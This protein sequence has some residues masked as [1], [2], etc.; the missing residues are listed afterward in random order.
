MAGRDA[1]CAGRYCWRLTRVQGGFWRDGALS[2]SA[3]SSCQHF[4]PSLPSLSLQTIK[5]ILETNT[6]LGNTSLLTHQP[7]AQDYGLLY[8]L[9]V[10]VNNGFTGDMYL[11]NI[12]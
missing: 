2:E 6:L 5:I 11:L 9:F 12:D 3:P 1:A 4:L 7:P 10:H 8:V